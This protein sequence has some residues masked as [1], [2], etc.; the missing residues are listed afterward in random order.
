MAQYII[1]PTFFA[2]KIKYNQDTGSVIYKSRMHLGKKR[3]FEV[4]DAVEFLHRICIHIPDPYESL[5]R[6]YG[7]YANAA[8]GKRKKL[9]LEKEDTGNIEIEIAEDAPS[10]RACR[11]SWSKLIYK[12][13]EV[14]PLKCPCCGSEMKIIAFIQDHQEIKKILK[15]IGLWP[16]EYPMPPPKTS[17][18]Y[19]ELL[20]K[21]A[22][23]RHLN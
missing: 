10:K 17:P 9:G 20:S 1:H 4:L 18:I 19:A 16:V 2:D 11:K 12:I 15:Y 13:Y 7:F 8:R 14:N 3:N 5:I 23:S 22:A 21:L 6:Y